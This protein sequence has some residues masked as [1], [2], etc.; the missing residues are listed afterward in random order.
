MTTPMAA[1]EAPGSNGRVET[2]IRIQPVNFA[3]LE[4]AIRGSTPYMQCRFSEK[5]QQKMAETQA[6]GQQARSRRTRAPRDFDGDYKAA[7]HA[8]RDGRY[9]IPAPAFRNAMISVCRLVGF[10]MTLAKLSIFVEHDALDAVDA[11][12]LVWITGT[13]ERTDLPVRNATGVVDIRVRPLWREWGALLRLKWDADQFS[14]EDVV[15][16]LDRAGQQVGIGEGR[17]DSK[18]SN[19]IGMGTFEV[20]R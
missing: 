13:P 17:P 20:M 12:P 10:K 19:G 15:N 6:A 16:L 1:A 9:G 11:S 5:A 4:V 2:A 18:N 8:D 7:F 3:R 14:A